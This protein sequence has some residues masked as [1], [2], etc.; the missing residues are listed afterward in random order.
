MYLNNYIVISLLLIIFVIIISQVFLKPNSPI[1]PVALKWHT[2]RADSAREWETPYIARIEAF[3][4][5]IE[6]NVATKDIIDLS[7]E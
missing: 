3:L 4:S 6:K 7:E 5:I 2:Y 1:P